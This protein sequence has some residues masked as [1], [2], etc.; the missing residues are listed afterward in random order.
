MSYAG[1]ATSIV[2]GELQGWAALLDKWAMA[3][4]YQKQAQTQAG[5]R[6][7]ALRLFNPQQFGAQAMQQELAQDSAQ[8]QQGY[9]DIN[10]TPLAVNQPGGN[11]AQQ[12]SAYLSLVGGQR[13]NLGAYSDW[14]VQQAIKNLQ[15][16][17]ALNQIKNFAGGEA[18]VFPLQ[19][20]KAQHAND[21]LAAAGQAISSLGGGA[22]NYSS[23]FGQVPPQGGTV[24]VGGQGGPAYFSGY[25]GAGNLPPQGTWYNPSTNQNT[26]GMPTYWAG[27]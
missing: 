2:G 27:G 20:Y 4:A 24:N 10:R 21:D 26:I 7:Q 22:A 15:T 14:A 11:T 1:A 17:N 6:D 13:A 23:L 25:G 3:D 8:R 12:D 18:G 19:M 9:S 5:F 16:Q